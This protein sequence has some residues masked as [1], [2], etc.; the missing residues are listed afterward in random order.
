MRIRV[1]GW[2]DFI[3][4]W[5]F[6]QITCWRG[7]RFALQMEFC[8][9][10]WILLFNSLNIFTGNEIHAARNLSLRVLLS[11]DFIWKYNN[12]EDIDAEGDQVCTTFLK[13]HG[14]TSYLMYFLTLHD[15]LSDIYKLQFLKNWYPAHICGQK[16]TWEAKKSKC[17]NHINWGLKRCELRGFQIWLQNS[18][19]VTFD[20]FLLKKQ[21]V[22]NMPNRVY[23]P[24]YC[25]FSTVF[26]CPK[27]GR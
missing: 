11:R 12:T 21:L 5:V 22:E 16:I 17:E 4:G 18:N 8:I 1:W 14:L 25:Q 24:T 7:R 2:H 20:P 6:G 13:T 3:F 10:N 15:E 19:R 9:N 23:L 26:F 27:K